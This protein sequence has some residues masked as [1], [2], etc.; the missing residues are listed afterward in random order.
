MKSLVAILLLTSFNVFAADPRSFDLLLTGKTAAGPHPNEEAAVRRLVARTVENLKVK[1]YLLRTT[2]TNGGFQVCLE[3]VA[4]G[5][6]E[7]IVG[8]L[9][10]I[11]VRES[12]WE[13]TLVDRC[14]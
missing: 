13:I 14:R 5:G 7:F 6:Y 4:D 10:A 12:I 8:E 11:A 1:K 2:P 9:S 3:P